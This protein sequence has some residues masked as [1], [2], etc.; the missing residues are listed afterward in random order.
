M[1][2]AELKRTWA[3]AESLGDEVP[4]YFYSH[5]FLSH[6]DTRDMFPVSMATQRDRLVGEIGQG[7][8]DGFQVK[9]A[10]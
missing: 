8:G 7:A 2:A 5:L 10:S 9:F 1:D 6:P 4:L 3:L